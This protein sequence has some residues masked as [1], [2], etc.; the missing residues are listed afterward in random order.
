MSSARIYG[1][2]CPNVSVE[3]DFSY[4]IQRPE[5]GWF[6]TIATTKTHARTCN[7][8]PCIQTAQNLSLFQT[9]TVLNNSLTKG[10]PS[11]RK[12][13]LWRYGL[14]VH[15]DNIAKHVLI[16]NGTQRKLRNHLQM[17]K[18]LLHVKH[19]CSPNIIWKVTGKK[20]WI[21]KNF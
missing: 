10:V 1:I 13:G 11:H 7:F 20:K 17:T 5:G 3:Y 18:S 15:F 4:P 16:L 9:Q 12:N 6:K 21:L 8:R 14:L 2:R 19:I